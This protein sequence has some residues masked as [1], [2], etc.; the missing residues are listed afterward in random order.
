MKKFTRS[1]PNRSL[2]EHSH[3]AGHTASQHV[4]RA[5]ASTSDVVSNANANGVDLSELLLDTGIGVHLLS[6]V[7]MLNGTRRF[8]VN[9]LGGPSTLHHIMGAI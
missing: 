1:Q 9:A 2:P 8:Q 5:I 3:P 7:H 6:T 4:D